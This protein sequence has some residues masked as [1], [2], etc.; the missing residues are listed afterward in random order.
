MCLKICSD[1]YSKIIYQLTWGDISLKEHSGHLVKLAQWARIKLLQLYNSVALQQRWISATAFSNN[2]CFEK[3]YIK[4]RN[5]AINSNSLRVDKLHCIMKKLETQR[6]SSP[7]LVALF[8]N[9]FKNLL[10]KCSPTYCKP[11]LV[12]QGHLVQLTQ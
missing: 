2:L 10:F 12:H 7:P 11:Y 9:L 6:N 4:D 5:Q 1:I 8:L 3:D